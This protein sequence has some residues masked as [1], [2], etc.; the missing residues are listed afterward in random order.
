VL[1]SLEEAI[2]SD[3]LESPQIVLKVVVREDC[4]TVLLRNR[5]AIVLTGEPYGRRSAQGRFHILDMKCGLDRL[6]FEAAG[7]ETDSKKKSGTLGYHFFGGLV[8][9]REFENCSE[10]GDLRD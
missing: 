5:L 7:V 3:A 6:V 2:A 8:L 4:Q 10:L 9:S 1:E